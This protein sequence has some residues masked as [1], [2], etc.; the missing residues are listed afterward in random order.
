[1]KAEFDRL[2][3]GID[4]V[5]GAGSEANLSPGLSQM[6]SVMRIL[7]SKPR[8]ILF[9]DADNGLDVTYYNNLF[10]LLGKIKPNVAMIV[11]SQDLNFR[12]LADRRLTLIEG[13]LVEADLRTYQPLPT[14]P[15]T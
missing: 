4:T 1:L 15:R 8:I 13:R 11:V 9:D 2:P 14:V 3:M 7:S 5:V 10:S 6:I 12:R